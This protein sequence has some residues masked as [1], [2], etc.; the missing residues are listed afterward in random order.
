MITLNEKLIIS[1]GYIYCVYLAAKNHPYA[2]SP[3]WAFV[4]GCVTQKER[5]AMFKQQQHCC[6]ESGADRKVAS[7]LQTLSGAAKKDYID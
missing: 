6:A 5:L 2:Q 1:S 4:R 3:T 7:A